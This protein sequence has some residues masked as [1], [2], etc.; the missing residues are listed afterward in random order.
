MPPAEKQGEDQAG[1]VLVEENPFPTVLINVRSGCFQLS[2]DS[3][4]HPYFCNYTGH[5][6]I[7]QKQYE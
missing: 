3:T 6:V 5:R 4:F 1:W 7:Q 2:V